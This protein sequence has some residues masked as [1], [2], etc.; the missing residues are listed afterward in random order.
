LTSPGSNAVYHR[1]TKHVEL[2]TCA[3]SSSAIAS[4]IRMPAYKDFW[5]PAESNIADGLS[6]ALTAAKFATVIRRALPSRAPRSAFQSRGDVR[7]MTQ[8]RVRKYDRGL[9][10]TTGGG[11]LNQLG[12]ADGGELSCRWRRVLIHRRLPHGDTGGFTEPL[13]DLQPLNRRDG[14]ES[15]RFRIRKG[16]LRPCQNSQSRRVLKV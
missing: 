10:I 9:L 2:W 11:D 3:T 1:R 12:R 7:V 14:R 13:L 6:K 5:V 4:L 16:H 15:A 8:H